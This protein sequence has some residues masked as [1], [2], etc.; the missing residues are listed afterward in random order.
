MFSH[1]N[2]NLPAICGQK[3]LFKNFG[4]QVVVCENFVEPKTKEG[5]FEKVGPHPGGRLADCGPGYKPGDSPV[6]LWTWL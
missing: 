1:S 3:C 2:N 6:P 4:I 5:H